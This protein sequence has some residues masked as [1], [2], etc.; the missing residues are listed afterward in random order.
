MTRGSATDRKERL[1]ARRD[2]LGRKKET[3]RK[4]QATPFMHE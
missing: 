1:R 3:D 4:R 2:L